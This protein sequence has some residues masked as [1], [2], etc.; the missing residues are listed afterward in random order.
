MKSAF[1]IPAALEVLRQAGFELRPPET[2]KLR[3]L[4]PNDVGQLIGVG[5]AKAREIA[6][7]L[8]NT[9]RLPGGDLR[10]TVSDLESWIAQH[11]LLKP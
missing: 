2:E 11:R 7:G 3:L 6:I 1:A 4:K 5:V 10:V 9:V 8:P